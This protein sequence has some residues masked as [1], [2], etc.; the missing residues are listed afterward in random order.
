MLKE[1]KN[2]NCSL[3]IQLCPHC[4]ILIEKVDGCNHMKCINCNY[5]FCWLC[6]KEYESIHYALYNFRGCPGMRFCNNILKKIQR[7]RK[8][9]T[10]TLL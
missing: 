4:N 8:N 3:N 7:K 2:N 10:I 6:L 9:V 1:F 5:E